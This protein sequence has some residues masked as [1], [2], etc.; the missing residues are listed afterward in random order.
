[1][2][3]CVFRADNRLSFLKVSTQPPTAS[4]VPQHSFPRRLLNGKHCGKARCQRNWLPE[5]NSLTLAPFHHLSQATVRSS[6]LGGNLFDASADPVNHPDDA[7]EN[8][9]AE[10]AAA[11]A[12][13][14]ITER[15]NLVRTL[16]SILRSK[17]QSTPAASDGT[18]KVGSTAPCSNVPTVA[19][20]EGAKAYLVATAERLELAGALVSFLP[21][22]RSEGVEGVTIASVASRPEWCA[23]P[24]VTANVCVCLLHL[25]DG[26]LS[27]RIAEQVR[28]LVGTLYVAFALFC[29]EGRV[30]GVP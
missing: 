9:P 28:R 8:S 20:P 11:T 26:E 1:M 5:I 21:P 12:A 6:T 2:G 17:P 13:A 3:V 25:L 19:V 7:A 4:N 30:P 15:E 18:R 23:P 22:A 14:Q 24:A 16:G 29:A 10:V 27:G